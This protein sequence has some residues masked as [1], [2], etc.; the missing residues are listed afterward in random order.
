MDD[1]NQCKMVIPAEDRLTVLREAHDT[2]QAGH[3][4]VEKTY[5]RIAIR[6]FWPR[7]FHDVMEYVRNCEV[8]QKTKVEQ[9]LPVGL[10]GRR[11]VSTPWS[12][13]AADIM[14]P[15]PTSKT[16]HSHILVL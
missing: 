7:L 6:Y 13:V 15:Q 8:C 16:G 4:G 10:M 9:R 3:L 5:H 1:L 11:V 2:P 12:V 14:G